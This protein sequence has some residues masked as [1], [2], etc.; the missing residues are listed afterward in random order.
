MRAFRTFVAVLIDEHIRDSIS[1]VQNEV[2][3]LAPDVKWVAPENLHVTLKFLGDVREDALPGV[4]AAVEKAAKSISGFELAVSGLGAFP[5]PQRARVVWVGTE[6][7]RDKLIE[8]AAA[9]ESELVSAGFAQEEKPFKA[10]ITI[11]RVRDRAPRQLPDALAEVNADALGSQRVSS[12][13]LMR[14]DLRPGGPVY[15]VTKTLPLL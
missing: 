15:S 4:L 5:N 9:V 2:N 14:S 12:V 13:A 8:L 10:H 6:D 11:G 3:K 7:G 1:R